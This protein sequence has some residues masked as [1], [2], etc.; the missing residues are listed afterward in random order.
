[1]RGSISLLLLTALGAAAC[2]PVPRDESA[3]IAR[4]LVGRWQYEYGDPDCR[5]FAQDGFR[6]NGTFTTTSSDCNLIDD[7]F[8]NYHYGWYV[9]REHLCYV[10][11]AEEMEDKSRGREKR[12]ALY[13]ARF[14]AMVKEGFVEDRCGQR[15]IEARTSRVV[16][17]TRSGERI[18]MKRD[19]SP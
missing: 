11:V 17:E 4:V 3:A 1:M 12:R 14:L 16:L 9:A 19:R 2:A 8:G 10:E 7:G 13:R 5:G 6:S 18:T 15:V